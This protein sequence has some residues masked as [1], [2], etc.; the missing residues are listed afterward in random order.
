MG[1]A[2]VA[3]ISFV[4]GMT[5]AIGLMMSGD[6]VSFMTGNTTRAAIS[7]EAGQY[8][9]ALKLF[10]AITTFVAG[11]A[12]GIIIA[13]IGQALP[14][15]LGAGYADSAS[16]A[17]ALALASPFISLQTPPADALTASDKQFV[18][19][20]IYFAVALASAGL[21]TLG[22]ILAGVWGAV[23]AVILSQA[24]LAAV[25]WTVVL[26]DGGSAR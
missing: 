17:A 6:F 8:D 7:L 22:A 18:R 15:V 20:I 10:L 12:A 19:T 14:F 24:L 5:D 21:L 13:I 25:L 3:A 16:I 2:L 23:A 4:A 11:N 9:H 1:L 26:L